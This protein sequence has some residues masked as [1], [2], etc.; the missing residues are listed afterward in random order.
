MS[1][2]ISGAARPAEHGK[3]G[4]PA[5]VKV[6]SADP[7]NRFIN[8]YSMLGVV[9][10]ASLGMLSAAAVTTLHG[11]RAGA[12]V[13]LGVATALTAAGMIIGVRKAEPIRVVTAETADAA[14]DLFKARP[15]IAKKLER[16]H[17]DADRTGAGIWDTVAERHDADGDGR[18]AI[19]STH[20][21]FA[22]ADTKFGNSDGYVT[23]DEWSKHVT[24]TNIDYGASRSF[25]RK[26]GIRDV[27]NRYTEV[28]LPNHISSE[29]ERKVTSERWF[30]PVPAE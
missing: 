3:L 27:D 13:G 7:V 12:L 6:E 9:G 29:L 18:I 16:N 15:D 14:R 2:S 25:G 17:V 24:E 11:G 8:G 20:S 26:V 19:A 10:G 22:T 30:T 1:I 5:S 23:K 28:R 21:P 4:Y